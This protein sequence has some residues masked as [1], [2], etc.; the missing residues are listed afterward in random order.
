[1]S[2]DGKRVAIGA[3]GNEENGGNSGHV[4]IYDYDPTGQQWN[5]VGQD[6]D[7]EAGGDYSGSSVAMSADGKRVAIGAYNNDDAGT[8]SGH[9]RIYDYDPTGHQWNQFGI[10]INGEAAGDKSGYS[11]ALSADGSQVVIG[12]Y[13]NNGGNGSKSG[14][15]RVYEVCIP[16][17][18]FSL[19]V[20]GVRF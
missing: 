5:Q 11:V 7:G 19:S 9:V 1:M 17:F 12:A 14:H 8:I 6:I 13:R 16:V 10:D 20:C 15:V 18:E 2:A 3:D 4:R